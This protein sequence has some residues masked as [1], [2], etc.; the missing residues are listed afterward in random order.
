[1]RRS[2][3][4]NLAQCVF[5]FDTLNDLPIEPPTF[6]LHAVQTHPQKRCTRCKEVKSI[7]DFYDIKTP[8]GKRKNSKC[9]V[10]SN[11]TRNESPDRQMSSRRSYLMRTYG[12]TLEDYDAMLE[13]QGGVCD[14]CG[15]P[16]ITKDQ[17]TGKILPLDVDHDH[18]TGKV[19]S[20]L[21][22]SCNNKLKV[23]EREAER[24]TA[25]LE[26]HK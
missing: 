8:T 3:P 17:R 10:C 22:N 12:L 6:K 1:M 4:Q 20:L 2:I 23:F 9:K 21:C 14:I 11:A 5:D 19:R 7:D 24:F 25:Y 15:G 26:R 16:Q 18:K 13:A